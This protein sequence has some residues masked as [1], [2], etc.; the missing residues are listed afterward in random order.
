M[1][2]KTNIYFIL[3]AVVVL[4]LGLAGIFG[5]YGW[6]LNKQKRVLTGTAR[7]TFPYG[8]YSLE[9]L[10]RLYPQ[11]PLENVKTTQT[12]EETYAKLIT[13]LKVGDIKLASESFIVKRQAEYLR[14][15]EKFKDDNKMSEIIKTLD[16]PIKLKE[17]LDSFAY[18]V[19]DSSSTS[20]I[21]FMKDLNGIWKIDSL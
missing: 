4:I 14:A 8:D 5:G 16:R 21:I 19:Y 10:N 7:S 1:E 11:Y 18:Y 13:A 9:E 6:F 2:R 15:L 3:G 20:E 17:K 12:S